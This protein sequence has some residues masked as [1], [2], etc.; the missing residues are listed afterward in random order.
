MFSS[1]AVVWF[2]AAREHTNHTHCV[3]LGLWLVF[4]GVCLAWDAGTDVLLQQICCKR[5]QL[6]SLLCQ[7]GW[8]SSFGVFGAFSAWR[9]AQPCFV[10]NCG[11]Y[12]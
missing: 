6:Q 5:C 1:E 11:S 9:A 2:G 8:L 12:V 10:L 4:L 7:V 3:V